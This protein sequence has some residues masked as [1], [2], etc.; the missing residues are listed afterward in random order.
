MEEANIDILGLKRKAAHIV[1]EYVDAHDKFL[2]P[3]SGC[4]SLW[5]TP[6]PGS[7]KVNFECC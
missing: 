1:K 7:W 3:I 2:V 5:T 6:S 4:E